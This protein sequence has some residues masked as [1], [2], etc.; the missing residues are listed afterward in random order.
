[1]GA[2]LSLT[3]L[4]KNDPDLGVCVIKS[5]E[6]KVCGVPS[7]QV[8]APH[9]TFSFCGHTPPSASHSLLIPVSWLA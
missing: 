6:P 5:K 2:K 3:K 9:G 8:S 1:M 7:C 4:N